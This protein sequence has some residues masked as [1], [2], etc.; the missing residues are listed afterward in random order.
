MAE[1]AHGAV[2]AH[3]AAL[4]THE[5]P[6]VSA[7]IVYPFIHG[8]PDGRM[9]V[10]ADEEAYPSSTFGPPIRLVRCTQVSE[11]TNGKLVVFEIEVDQER[12]GHPHRGPRRALYCVA[13]TDGEWRLIWRHFL[14]YL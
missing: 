5:K 10:Y 4:N 14:G 13:E 1:S 7:T 9:T 8:M 12:D 3:I 6:P 11:S 2:E